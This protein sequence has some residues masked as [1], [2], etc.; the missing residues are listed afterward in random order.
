MHSQK[1]PM[2]NNSGEDKSQ[3]LDHM[4]ATHAEGTCEGVS[5]FAVLNITTAITV[6]VLLAL[7]IQLVLLLLLF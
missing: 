6:K 2:R 1:P 4:L 7:L 3:A 5:A